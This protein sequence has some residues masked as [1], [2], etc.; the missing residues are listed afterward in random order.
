MPSTPSIDNNKTTI[1]KDESGKVLKPEEKGT[2]DKGKIS[3]Y[4]Y[5]RT[6]VD[7]DGNTVHIFRK[8]TVITPV[9]SSKKKEENKTVNKVQTK[10]L[11]NTG[12]T[13]QNTGLAGLGLALLSATLVAIKR[14]KR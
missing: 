2:K 12:T 14:R 13:Q 5:V 11:A 3:G 4:E 6:V 10:R 9:E 7:K 8:V 1:W